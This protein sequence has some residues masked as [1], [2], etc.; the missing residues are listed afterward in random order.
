MFE[1][2]KFL[3]VHSYFILFCLELLFLKKVAKKQE[4][5]NLSWKK[6]SVQEQS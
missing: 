2:A 5:K 6:K 3:T 4:E 1:L